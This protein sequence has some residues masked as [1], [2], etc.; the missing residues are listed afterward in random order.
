MDRPYA[1]IIESGRNRI[2]FFN[3]PVLALH[4]KSLAAM[5]NPDFAKLYSSCGHTGIDTLSS[6][7][8]KNYFYPIVINIMINR[9]G[10]ITAATDTG[11]KVIRI[12]PSFLQR[13]LFPYLLTNHRLQ[14]GY[15]IGI[16]MR[17]YCR[18]DYI[19]G[20]RRMTAP[21]SYRLIRSIF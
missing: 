21:V 13:E 5:N 6:G 18:S 7:L 1:G 9:S 3:L 4:N 12:I 10:S 11:N 14:A 15:H 2:R 19:I 17:S 16:R 20:I 8:R